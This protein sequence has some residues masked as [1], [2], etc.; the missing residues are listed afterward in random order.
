MTTVKDSIDALAPKVTLAQLKAVLNDLLQVT[1]LK[2][3]G[4]TG[5]DASYNADL[6]N[7]LIASGVANIAIP[8]GVV[9][10]CNELLID[11]KRVTILSAGLTSPVRTSSNTKPRLLANSNLSDH[12]ITLTGE[13]SYLTL[14]GLDVHGNRDNQTL[15]LDAIHADAVTTPLRGSLVI[16]NTNVRF[17]SGTAVN[18]GSYRHSWVVKNHSALL[19]ADGYGL[20]SEGCE[21]VF[22]ENS[23]CGETGKTAVHIDGATTNNVSNIRLSN[24]DIYRGGLADPGEVTPNTSIGDY[25]NIHIGQYV[26][27]SKLMFGESLGAYRHGISYARGANSD[28]YST[29][30][31]IGTRF[32]SNSRADTDTYADV[33]TEVGSLSAIGNIH[34]RFR[35]EPGSRVKYLYQVSDDVLPG[36]LVK[37]VGAQYAAPASGYSG[38]YSTAVTNDTDLVVVS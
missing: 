11:G 31:L 38:S 25:D 23:E 20:K 28:D 17:A 9:Y 7:D 32:T 30:Y 22:F 34:S 15:D 18:I 16:D 19:A 26:F 14:S 8:G 13:D 35:D 36:E 2:S 29:H 27:S 5:T 4:S 33:Y 1:E 21:D 3:T 12:F 10:P 6:L 24:F 37:V